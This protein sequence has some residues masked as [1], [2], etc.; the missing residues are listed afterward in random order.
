MKQLL[1]FILLLTVFMT[2]EAQQDNKKSAFAFVF[3]RFN[4]GEDVYEIRMDT[5]QAAI[6]KWAST[7]TD[8][9]GKALNFVSPAAAF[10]YVVSSGWKFQ[11]AIW[12][13]QSYLF[14]KD[15]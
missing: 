8:S 15:D 12:A 5:G 9:S 13:T 4:A 6:S 10:N 3:I 1:F 14:K 7:M 11:E 2:V